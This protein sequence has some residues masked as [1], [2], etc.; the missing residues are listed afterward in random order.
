MNTKILSNFGAYIKKNYVKKQ[1]Y[2][3]KNLLKNSIFTEP[4]SVLLSA[5]SEIQ[6]Y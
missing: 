6:V 4:M 3:K 2:L 1:V 5:G